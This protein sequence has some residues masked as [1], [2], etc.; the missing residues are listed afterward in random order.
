[1]LFRSS[2]LERAQKAEA[3]NAAL[4]GALE[5]VH[6]LVIAWTMDLEVKPAPTLSRICK[7][8]EPL[9]ST[10]AAPGTP[11][12]DAVRALCEAAEAVVTHDCNHPTHEGYAPCVVCWDTQVDLETALE[13]ALAAV[14]R[15]LP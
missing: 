5:R 11:L 8:T 3:D 2:T 14:R 12:L 10:Y 15:V 9:V 7:I 1:M 13:Q 4:R 6:G